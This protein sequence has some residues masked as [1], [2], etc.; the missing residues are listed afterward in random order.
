MTNNVTI[1]GWWFGT[2]FI[3]PNKWENKN[4]IPTDEIVLFFSEGFGTMNQNQIAK[5]L[6]FMS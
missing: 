2:V 1:A 6:G 5:I 4:T 3:L